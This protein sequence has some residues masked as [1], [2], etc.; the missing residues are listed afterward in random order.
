MCTAYYTL[1]GIM[2]IVGINFI[3]VVLSMCKIQQITHKLNKALYV[4]FV[5]DSRS[6]YIA[7]IGFIDV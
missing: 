5:G 2:V 6:L 7:E 4:K 3:F 1:Q